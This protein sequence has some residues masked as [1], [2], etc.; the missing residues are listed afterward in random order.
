MQNFSVLLH[1][2]LYFCLFA[3]LQQCNVFA[4]YF[5]YL[6]SFSYFQ[7][8]FDL[9]FIFPQFQCI[10]SYSSTF[11]FSRLRQDLNTLGKDN[12]KLSV[13]DFIIKASSLALKK[14]PECNSSWMGDFIRRF[15]FSINFL[16]AQT[17]SPLLLDILADNVIVYNLMRFHI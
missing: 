6:N 14:V 10:Q 15:D 3:C 11:V 13:N 5:T 4:P 7:L 16:L 1:I 2:L 17:L 9:S 12:Y 8:F